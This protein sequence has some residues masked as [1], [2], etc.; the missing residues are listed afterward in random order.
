MWQHL[1]WLCIVA[2]AL[3]S[4]LVWD[5]WLTLMKCD[6]VR[7]GMLRHY[8]ASTTN[9]LKRQWW[10]GYSPS[11]L[12]HS[13]SASGA[14]CPT[15]IIWHRD[16]K[17]V[18]LFSA[19]VLWESSFGAPRRIP[20]CFW[21]SISITLN[22][23]HKKAPT[24]WLRLEAVIGYRFISERGIRD[25]WPSFE[26]VVLFV[27]HRNWKYFVLLNNGALKPWSKAIF[28]RRSFYPPN[29]VWL[30]VP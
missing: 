27:G 30:N 24:S 9:A 4:R 29:E 13:L 15:R 16:E 14:Y 10:I 28:C 23:P 19:S 18:V 22:W 8:G 1:D 5:L 7:P 3:D 2:Q 11:F 17:L 12:T 26:G 21:T 6:C 25:A 20:E